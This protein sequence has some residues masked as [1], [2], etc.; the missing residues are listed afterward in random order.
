MNIQVKNEN[1]RETAK[2]K[3]ILVYFLLIAFNEEFKKMKMLG[4]CQF[5]RTNILILMYS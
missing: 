4:N 3:I 2:S 1:T 5:K